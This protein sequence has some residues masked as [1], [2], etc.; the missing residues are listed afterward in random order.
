M[1][2][3]PTETCMDYLQRVVDTL[4]QNEDWFVLDQL[5]TVEA[6]LEYADLLDTYGVESLL[7]LGEEIE[8]G[9]HDAGAYNEFLARYDLR[10]RRHYLVTKD[11]DTDDDDDDL[12]EDLDGDTSDS[13]NGCSLAMA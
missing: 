12:D 2:K 7:F 10:W 8:I 11:D 1:P 3:Q 13:P 4:M 9:N 6:V 5:P